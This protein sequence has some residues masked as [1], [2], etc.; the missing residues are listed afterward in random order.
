MKNTQK[1]IL[2]TYKMDYLISEIFYTNLKV[3]TKQNIRA[4]PQFLKKKTEKNHHRKPPK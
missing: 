4:E 3:K 2:K 1:T